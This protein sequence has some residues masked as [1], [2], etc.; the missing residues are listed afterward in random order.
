[1]ASR[2]LN[3]PQAYGSGVVMIPF[4][5]TGLE[6]GGGTGMDILNLVPPDGYS[7]EVSV[8]GAGVVRVTTKDAFGEVLMG[9]LECGQVNPDFDSVFSGV[10][11]L[12]DNRRTVELTQYENIA[13]A[14][15]PVYYTANFQGLFIV[16]NSSAKF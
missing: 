13:G 16:R 11:S 10:S 12:F 9:M 5:F 6:T 3:F 1:M 14:R 2:N 8:Q 7:V 4:S 15:T